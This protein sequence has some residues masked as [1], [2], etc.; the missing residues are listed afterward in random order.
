MKHF[1]AEDDGSFVGGETTPRLSTRTASATV[2]DIVS[3]VGVALEPPTIRELC[4]KMQLGPAHYDEATA[5][6]VVT[7]PP[8]RS[9]ILHSVDV[10]EDVAIAYGFNNLMPGKTPDT[11]AVGAPLP[12]NHFCDQLRDEVA[13]AGYTEMLTHGLCMTAENFAYLGRPNDGSA[14]QLSN[15][16]NEEY[17]VVRTTLLPGILKCLNHNKSM[18]K[19]NGEFSHVSCPPSRLFPYALTPLRCSPSGQASSFSR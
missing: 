7:V 11:L 18:P 4:T 3:I 15:P 16:A 8:T 6:V 12:V 2:A 14:V 1:G 9:D 17:E 13:R 10:I 19:K 5:S